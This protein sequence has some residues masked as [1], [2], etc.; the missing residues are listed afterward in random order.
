MTEDENEPSPRDAAID[1]LMR[2]NEGRLS[3][4]EQAEFSAW[5]AEDAHRAAF[6]D[7]CA[8]YGRLTAMEFGAAPVRRRRASGRLLA[9]AVTAGAVVAATLVLHFDDL[10]L[11]LRSDHYAGA[12]ETKRVTLADGSRV[13]LDARSA[14]AL[15][16][17]PQER[18]LT[19][20]EGEAWFEVAPDPS[21][22]FVVAAG[23]GTVT[24]LGTAFDVALRRGE[25]EVTVAEHSVAVASGGRTI[26]V[27]QGESSA[28]T[29][30]AAAQEPQKTDVARATSWRQGALIFENAPLGEVVEALSRYHRGHV[31]FADPSLRA[32]RVSGVFG[33]NDP[34]EA[35]EEIEAAVGLREVALTR[36]LI[37]LYR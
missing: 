19:L 24:A 36:Y 20:L 15:H 7:I 11:T 13:E 25:T 4:A 16:F 17:S 30:Q 29:P 6:E 37:V 27:G 21:R 35:L 22:P 1:W 10:S 34:R 3:R 26:V 33:S 23:G 8:M 28:Y 9:G 5:L 31:L 14:I 32:R 2:C 12:G 18:R